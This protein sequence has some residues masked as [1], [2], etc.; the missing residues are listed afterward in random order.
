MIFKNSYK[1]LHILYNDSNDILIFN[2]SHYKIIKN[3]MKIMTNILSF[4]KWN[5]II[6]IKNLKNVRIIHI[7]LIIIHLNEKEF[8]IE[9]EN[10]EIICIELNSF[11]EKYIKW[12]KIINLEK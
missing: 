11:I 10:Q 5:V 1:I 9:Y 3:Y 12:L 2:L 8:I 7:I 6:N 4:D